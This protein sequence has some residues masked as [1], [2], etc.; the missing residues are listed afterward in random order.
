MKT[1]T[2]FVS[3]SSSSS[4]VLEVGKPF[5]TALDVAE[6]M[7]PCRKWDGDGELLEKIGK[8]RKEGLSESA[9]SYSR[10]G[11]LPPA[12][13]F[14]S[15]NHD[16]FIAKMGNFFLVETCHNHDWNLYDVSVSD[17]VPHEF[18][19]YFGDDSFYDLPRRI[20]FYHLEYDVVVRRPDCRET[21][22]R[23]CDTC[24]DDYWVVGERITCL[25]CK[26]EFPKK[27]E[28]S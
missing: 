13:C 18:L 26:T 21:K 15:C 19:E 25:N 5:D 27:N 9:R 14:S 20:P 12:I 16:T 4:F 10:C 11:N 6:H 1:R 24:H 28:K 3:N 17:I 8:L 22:Y 7:I 2:G 23:W